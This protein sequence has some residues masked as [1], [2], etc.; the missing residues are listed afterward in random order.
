[1]H[2]SGQT[3][4]L[5]VNVCNYTIHIF[6]GMSQEDF[7]FAAYEYD[8]ESLETDS[9]DSEPEY[10]TE[11]SFDRDEQVCTHLLPLLPHLTL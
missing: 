2:Y 5:K 3:N 8:S 1:M 10:D 9:D 6:A 7:W 11:F 4:K